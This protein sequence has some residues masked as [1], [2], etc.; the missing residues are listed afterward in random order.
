[1]GGRGECSDLPRL[2]GGSGG[3]GGSSSSAGTRISDWQFSLPAVVGEPFASPGCRPRWRR[4]CSGHS[5]GGSRGSSSCCRG[6]GWGCR[7]WW[8]SCRRCRRRCCCCGAGG[9]GSGRCCWRRGWC[10]SAQLHA[11][12]DCA[13]SGR[14]GTFPRLF[15]ATARAAPAWGIRHRSAAGAL[16]GGV[17]AAKR[18][19]AQLRTQGGAVLVGHPR[20]GL[21]LEWC[22][23]RV[24][25]ACCI[26][27]KILT[28]H[29]S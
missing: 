15:A 1:M 20:H 14:V 11:P 24:T 16:P 2:A 23:S 10:C 28:Y 29:P 22:N 21:T 26:L 7:R 12:H 27:N 17:F 19:G 25:L 9:F 3:S 4:S 13:S 6:H 18:R 5:R 8:R